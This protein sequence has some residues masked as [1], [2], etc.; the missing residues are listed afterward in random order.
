MFSGTIPFHHLTTPQVFVEIP[1]GTRSPRSS[2]PKAI[3]DE[4]WECIDRCWSQDRRARPLVD[5]ARF[6][7]QFCS[8]QMMETLAQRRIKGRN[9]GRRVKP[10]THSPSDTESAN[11]EPLAGAMP[12]STHLADTTP[13]KNRSCNAPV[14]TTQSTGRPQ[15]ALSTRN[16]GL[17]PRLSVRYLACLYPGAQYLVAQRTYRLPSAPIIEDHWRPLQNHIMFYTNK[18]SGCGIACTDALEGKF[19]HLDGQDDS[20]MS[21]QGSITVRILVSIAR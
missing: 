7:L 14:Q 12:P 19:G 11:D 20:L 4:I 16:L 17:Q 13:T 18:N 8:S 3:T 2:S 5:A 6:T 9:S 15:S 10:G 21:I 1:R